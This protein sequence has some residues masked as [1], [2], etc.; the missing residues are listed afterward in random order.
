MPYEIP[1]AHHQQQHDHQRGHEHHQGQPDVVP[2][3]GGRTAVGAGLPSGGRGRAGGAC[4][5]SAAGAGGCWAARAAGAP[6]AAPPGG[7]TGAVRG[8]RGPSFAPGPA[9]RAARR[10]AGRPYP[11]IAPGSRG[12][13][14]RR[15]RRQPDVL[16]WRTP[17]ARGRETGRAQRRAA[18]TRPSSLSAGADEGGRWEA[19][20]LPET[21]ANVS[22]GG[23]YTGCP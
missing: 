2:H 18:A 16:P 7:G 12:R 6:S 9:G 20:Q 3:L 1:T 22:H 15:P 17:R 14:A 21:A 5:A 11:L 13:V 23:R 4:W 19:P 10:D 8:R